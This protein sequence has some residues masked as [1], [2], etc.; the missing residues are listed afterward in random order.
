MSNG[1]R[2]AAT[3][4]PMSQSP[5]SLPPP[6][7]NAGSEW[8]EPDRSAAAPRRAATL[9][10]IIGGVQI[11]VFGS[12]SVIYG[13]LSLLTADQV[14][15]MAPGNDTLVRQFEQVHPALPVMAVMLLV[16][17]FLP[18]LAYLVLAFGVRRGR[19]HPMLFAQLLLITQLIVFGVLFAHAAIVAVMNRD[20]LQ[21]TVAILVLGTGIALLAFGL[22]WVYQSR[23]Y[24]ERGGDGGSGAWKDGLP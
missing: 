17:G 18:G 19:R 8:D 21:L 5:S 1:G 14:A 13:I 22:Y 4:P 23:Q 15:A 11:V 3:L 9:L 7:G 12:C 10:W 24:H 2:R 6:T 16:L 20:P